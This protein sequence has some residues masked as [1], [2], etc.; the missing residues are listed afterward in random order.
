MI[1]ATHAAGPGCAADRPPLSTLAADMDVATG[2]VQL[3]SLVQG[4]YARVSERH[5]LTPVQAKLLC[6]LLD[7]P[8]GMADL[9]QCFGVE[10]AALTGLMDRAERRGLA[11]RAPVAGDRRALQAT[12][13]AT[14][15]QTAHAFHTEV[16]AELSHLTTALDPADREHFRATMAGII[17]R[18]RNASGSS[19]SAMQTRT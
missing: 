19:N 13:T 12:L 15:R 5:E 1:A 16:S 6:V 2:L 18:C 14:G 8:R 9:A 10:K 3:T 11:Q 4:I 17:Q 7:G